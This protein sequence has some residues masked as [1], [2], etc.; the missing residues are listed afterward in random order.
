MLGGVAGKQTKDVW[1][2]VVV[3]R[4]WEEWLSFR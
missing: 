1:A 4:E 2:F 3:K